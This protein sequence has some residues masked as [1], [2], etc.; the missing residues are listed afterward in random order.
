MPLHPCPCPSHLQGRHWFGEDGLVKVSGVT[1]Q[2][3]LLRPDAVE[4]ANVHQSREELQVYRNV[5]V[6]SSS[7]ATVDT[8][9]SLST[10]VLL[11]S[12]Q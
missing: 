2:P 11:G 9:A 4:Y 10:N 3:E 6:A 8:A 7:T 12:V 1:L 5:S